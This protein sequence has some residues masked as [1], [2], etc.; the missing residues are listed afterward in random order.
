VGSIWTAAND[1]YLRVLRGLIPRGVLWTRDEASR[2]TKFLRGMADELVRAHNSASNLMTEADPQTATPAGSLSDWER[3]AGLP[4]FGYI[5]TLEA[6]RR[7][8]LLGKLAA[9]GGQS[10]AYFVQ[11]ALAYGF[12]AVCS[13]GPWAFW[14][15][16][17]A[18]AAVTRKVAGAPIGVGLVTVSASGKRLTHAFT[19][20]K[21]AHSVIWWTHL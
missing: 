17:S 12:T 11:V 13:K 19:R 14:W 9:Q 6:D 1:D 16:V 3:V 4:E 5:P 2:L 18:P 21:P 15:T 20:Y 8:T 10:A 7:A